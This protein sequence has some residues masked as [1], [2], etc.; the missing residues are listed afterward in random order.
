MALKRP[1]ALEVATRALATRDYSERGLR[2]RLRRAGV[3][4][5]EEEHAVQ[6]LR[7]TGVL[8]DGRFAHSRAQALAARGQGDAA[9]RFDLRRQGVAGDEIEAA[10]ALLEPER[11]R[12]QRVVERRGS[13]AATARLL[14]R[15]GFDEDVVEAAVAHEA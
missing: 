10:L 8:D 14:A 7:C 2:E 13:D 4:Q 12:A 11:V 15:R 5:G 3:D 9:I 1:R 6:A